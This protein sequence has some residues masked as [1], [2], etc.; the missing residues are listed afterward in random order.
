MAWVSS[1]DPLLVSCL[2]AFASY[3]SLGILFLL[4]ENLGVPVLLGGIH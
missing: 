3:Y 4:P 1:L 2:N